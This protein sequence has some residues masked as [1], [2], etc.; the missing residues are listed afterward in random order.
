M[1]PRILIREMRDE[2]AE[3]AL[4]VHFNAVHRTAA[5]HYSRFILDAWA[6]P[7]DEAKISRFRRN[8]Y[9]EWRIVA[10]LEGRIAGFCALEP[11]NGELR[12]CYVSPE[13]S[14]KGIGRSLV[15]SL[16]EEARRY[17]LTRLR[18][19]S[20]LTALGFY[21]RLGFSIVPTKTMPHMHEISP[22]ILMRCVYMGK[23]LV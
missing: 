4:T 23:A 20:S 6:P 18:L 7:I 11:K 19:D 15:H 21:Q 3:E 8:F 2:D 10:T 12:S 5:G 1:T 16:E 14:G 22:N 13:A 17:N 9:N